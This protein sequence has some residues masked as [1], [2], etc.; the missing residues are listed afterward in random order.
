MCFIFL[1]KH[2]VAIRRNLSSKKEVFFPF[3]LFSYFFITAMTD[4]QH[5]KKA[6]QR[7]WQQF[8]E[9]VDTDWPC[10]VFTFNSFFAKTN[11]KPEKYYFEVIS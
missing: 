4:K 10:A 7:E 3:V 9:K 5:C 6:Q 1:Q 11:L 2:V 8:G